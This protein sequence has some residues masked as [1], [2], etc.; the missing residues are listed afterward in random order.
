M[1]RHSSAWWQNSRRRPGE[2]QELLSRTKHNKAQREIE[3]RNYTQLHQL[4]AG[5]VPGFKII[6]EASLC[7]FFERGAFAA[8]IGESFASEMKRAGDQDRIWLRTGKHQRVA[9]R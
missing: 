2:C 6:A 9:N 8:Q 3:R 5:G 7:A 1:Q 4:P